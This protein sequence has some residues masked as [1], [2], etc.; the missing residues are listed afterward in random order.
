MKRP[1]FPTVEVS[2]STARHPDDVA[3]E[4]EAEADALACGD[5]LLRPHVDE[6][7]K[8]ITTYGDHDAELAL[9]R[10]REWFWGYDLKPAA[11]SG[12][13]GAGGDGT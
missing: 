1:R 10:M 4:R 12:R 2:P 9:A 6:V 7:L 3:S 8:L 13:E 11:P 5:A